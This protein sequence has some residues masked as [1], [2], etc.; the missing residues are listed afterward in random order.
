MSEDFYGFEYSLNFNTVY[1]NLLNISFGNNFMLYRD[2][3]A[4]ATLGVVAFYCV[5]YAVKLSRATT[6]I[7]FFIA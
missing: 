3:T 1:H 5:P 2:C 4:T 7:K 6:K